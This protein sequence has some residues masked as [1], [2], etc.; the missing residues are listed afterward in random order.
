MTLLLILSTHL[1]KPVK[2]ILNA[3]NHT[4]QFVFKAHNLNPFDTIGIEELSGRS[5]QPVGIV[6]CG[7]RRQNMHSPIT[8]CILCCTP[9][10]VLQKFFEIRHILIHH[11]VWQ[12][13]WIWLQ[14]LQQPQTA[15]C[16]VP[17]VSRCIN[18]ELQVGTTLRILK[19]VWE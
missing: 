2:K 11:K 9:H 19:K 3:M 7:W 8:T 16:H 12:V 17:V 1:A 5:D 6:T 14:L 10:L 18:E 13:A 4:F 15:K